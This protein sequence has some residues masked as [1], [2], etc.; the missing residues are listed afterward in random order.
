MARSSPIRGRSSDGSCP[1]AASASLCTPTVL[2]GLQAE[3]AHFPT[4]P[5]FE[6]RDDA[7]AQCHRRGPALGDQELAIS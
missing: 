7:R 6:L 5:V 2:D 3:L 1:A 4:L